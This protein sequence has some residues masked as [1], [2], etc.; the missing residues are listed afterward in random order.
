MASSAT[1][2]YSQASVPVAELDGGG[3][4]LDLDQISFEGEIAEYDNTLNFYIP[5][6]FDPDAVFGTR[7]TDTA[8]DDWLN[9]YANYDLESGQVDS[10]LSVFLMCGDGNEF[11]FSYPLNAEEQELLR[12]KME[13]YCQQMTGQSLEEYQAALFSPEQEQGLGPLAP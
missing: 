7:V 3:S 1:A 6:T 13:D 11:E 10:A 4:R 2:P 5:V 8:N 12:Q 9:V